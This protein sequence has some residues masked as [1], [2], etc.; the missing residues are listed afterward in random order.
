M[1]FVVKEHSNKGAKLINISGL[2]AIGIFV[3]LRLRTLFILPGMGCQSTL[4]AIL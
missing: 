2:A 1:E 3:T 4:T